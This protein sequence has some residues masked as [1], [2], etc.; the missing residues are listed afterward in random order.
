[1]NWRPVVHFLARI[2]EIQL[3]L[4]LSALDDLLTIL[5]GSA[6]G[7]STAR[8]VTFPVAKVPYQCFV[9]FNT[10]TT[11]NKFLNPLVGLASVLLLG[12][13]QVLG[14]NVCF[15]AAY[16]CAS[17][18]L[19]ELVPCFEVVDQYLLVGD[20]DT[21]TLSNVLEWRA[22]SVAV[23]CQAYAVAVINHQNSDIKRI[24]ALCWELPEM[25]PL[26]LIKHQPSAVA[27]L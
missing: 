14:K 5:L 19:A 21:D 27:Y 9:Q 6:V 12:G 16:V 24:K 17:K 11:F 18:R 13:C 20:R 23:I 25:L 7:H 22:V 2:A 3:C 15:V 4:A 26:F 8:K 10:E 1:M